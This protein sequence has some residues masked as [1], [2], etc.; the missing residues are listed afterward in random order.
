MVFEN[1]CISFKWLCNIFFGKITMQ[2]GENVI[3]VQKNDCLNS[4]YFKAVLYS[5][6]QFLFCS[7]S[8]QFL[9]YEYQRYLNTYQQRVIAVPVKRK[10]GFL[11]FH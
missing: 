4:I 9:M 7:S 6:I 10:R 8:K 5:D 3:S 1:K 11:H 2:K